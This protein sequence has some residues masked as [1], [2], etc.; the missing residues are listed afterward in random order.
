MA[1]TLNASTTAGLVQTADTS[2][3]LALQTAGTTAVTVDA[4][5]NVG[6][7]T[8]SP[9]KLLEV[10]ST[11]TNL[12][13]MRVTGTGTTANNYR[14]YEFAS[15]SGFTGGIFQ[16][17]STSN[18][19][20]WGNSSALMTLDSS[21]NLGIGANISG[22]YKLEVNGNIVAR[23]TTDNNP[24]F[25]S[26][27][28]S[29]STCF[30]ESINGL[31]ASFLPINF[32]QTHTGTS[33]T[34]MVL[35][36]SGNL[37][38][39]TTSAVGKL[40]VSDANNRTEGTSQFSLAGSGYAAYHFLDATAYYIGQNSNIRELR[41]YSG[42]SSAVGVRLTS[43]NNA[44]QTYSDE[45]M[46]D[47]IEPIENAAQKVSTLRTVIG[48]YKTDA[49]DKRRVFMI[50]QDVQAVLPEAVTTDAEGMLGM[51]YDHIVPL[52]TAAIKEQQA[53]ITQLQA[54]V[55]ALKGASA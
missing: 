19:Q 27:S 39:G 2:G 9:A 17:E 15:G 55:A 18:L 53:L 12:A 25:F 5:Q 49:I 21:G 8:T 45:R 4:S 35:D 29:S 32:K 41:I 44:W 26:M 16:D 3:V 54:D 52:L 50:A 11:T 43:G 36:A 30:L 14:G 1:V 31:A 33:Q 48:K 10:K 22:L 40:T 7:G 24:H 37:L 47:I 6:I 46:K 34:P 42:S 13:R 51:A 28:N 20:F 38:V 23:R